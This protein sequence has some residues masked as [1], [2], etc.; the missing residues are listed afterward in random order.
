MDETAQDKE[1]GREKH[2][3]DESVV[4]EPVEAPSQSPDVIPDGGYG[5]VCVACVSLI[6]AHTCKLHLREW[7]KFDGSELIIWTGG[8]NSVSD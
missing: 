8:I 3:S 4:S 6:N 1:I 5:W 2:D 7:E